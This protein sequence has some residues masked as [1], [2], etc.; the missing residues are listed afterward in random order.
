[1]SS[2]ETWVLNET[3]SDTYQGSGG[4]SATF[5][6]NSETFIGIGFDGKPNGIRYEQSTNEVLVY[7]FG[8]NSW[9]DQAYRTLTFAIPP[10]GDLL[11]WLQANGTKQ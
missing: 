5:T 7:N 11:T 3:I 8:D 2:G 4:F 9:T 1:M 10:T 6:S